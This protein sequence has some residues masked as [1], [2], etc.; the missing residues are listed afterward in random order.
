MTE[1]IKNEQKSFS[2]LF[3]MKFK[4]DGSWTAENYGSARTFRKKNRKERRIEKAVTKR[5]SKIK[6]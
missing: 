3:G 2:D 5:L 6:K 1:E 4:E